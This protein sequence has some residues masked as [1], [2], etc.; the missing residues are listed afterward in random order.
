[1]YLPLLQK[2]VSRYRYLKST[3]EYDDISDT[4]KMRGRGT[5]D[6]I[7]QHPVIEIIKSVF[8][9]AR[10]ILIEPNTADKDDS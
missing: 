2:P 9:Q 8:P 4:Y 7:L 5:M 6:N 1:M 10:V 3:S